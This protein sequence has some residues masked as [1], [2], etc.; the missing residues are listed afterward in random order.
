V[1]EILPLTDNPNASQQQFRVTFSKPVTGVDPTDFSASGSKSA[2]VVSV[3]GSGAVYTVTA[4]LGGGT[5]PVQLQVK[6]DDSIKDASLTP[7][8]GLGADNGGFSYNGPMTHS[9]PVF[10]GDNDFDTAMQ[11]LDETFSPVNWMLGGQRFSPDLCDA[12]GGTISVQPPQIVG[13]DMKD[14]CELGII[15]ECLGNPAL[16]LSANRGVTHAM[17]QEAWDRNITRMVADLGGPNGRI[18]QSVPGLDLL[19]AGYMTLGNPESTVVP[20]LLMSAISVIIALPPGTAIPV[21]KNYVGLGSYFGPDGDADGDGFANREEYDYFMPLGG[22]NLYIQA[23]LDPTMKPGDQTPLHSSGGTFHQG[24][25]F[26]LGVPGTLDLSGGFQWR[27]DGQPIQNTNTIFGTHWC[28]LQI[29]HLGKDDGG[30]YDCVNATGQRIFGPVVV[31]VNPMPAAST[32]GLLAIVLVTAAVG[33]R[34]LRKR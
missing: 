33:A 4:N 6:D 17:V 22:R 14:G 23:A 16:D 21:T 31:S 11:S 1:Y 29:T 20:S 26:S 30:I 3:T 24:E 15:H 19:M 8:G 2:S 10:T 5:G 18:R 9:D 27:K 12:N 7:L 13:N 32:A 34:R 28:D 25:A